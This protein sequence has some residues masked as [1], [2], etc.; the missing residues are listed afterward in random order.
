MIYL[1]TGGFSKKTFLEV[2]ELFDKSIVRGLELSGGR[3]TESLEMGLDEVEKNYKIA[4]HNY[5]PVPKDSFVF[6]LASFDK[7]IISASMNHAKMAIE[8]S[9]KYKSNYFSFHAGYLLDPNPTEL[10]KSITK[11]KLNN[12]QEGLKQFIRN[13]NELASFA[14][15]KDI[16]LL[17]ENNVLSERNFKT[18]GCDPL[19]MTGPSET[20]DIF[21][22]VAK[23]VKLLID[24]AH[25]KVSANT[26]SFDPVAYLND[27]KN[28]TDAYHISDNNG[29]ED[30][31][32][33]FTEESWFVNHI[34]KDL[35]YYS[36]EI[37]L[38]DTTKLESQYSLMSDVLR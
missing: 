3:Y 7:G 6:N 16:T 19:L 31:N 1:S 34:R 5:F 28:I 2:S 38:S 13:V 37:Y 18:F 4:L 15:E 30:S 11:N 21:N 20:E 33:P 14:K 36:L 27:F 17:I 12:R 9:H 8:L 35:D 32:Q 22:N 29:L 26:L 25:L 24:V 10:G 23:N